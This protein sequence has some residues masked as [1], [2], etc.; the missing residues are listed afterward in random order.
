MKAFL[1]HHHAPIEQKPLALEEVPIPLPSEEDVLVE[2]FVCGICRT[3][4]HVIEGELSQKPLPLIPGHQIVGRIKTIGSKVSALSVGQRVGIAWLQATCGSCKF[5]LRGQENLCNTTSFTGWTRPG[6][7]AE[8]VVA[9]T[10]FIYPLPEGISDQQAAP[11]LCAG[12][13]GY[14]SLRLTGLSDWYGRKIGLY[15]FGSAAHISIQLLKSWGADVYV[16]SREQKHLDLATELGACW[17]GKTT[18]SLMQKLDA[19]IIY[20]PAGE[21]VV[22]A[23]QVSDKGGA[24]VC[25]GIHMSPIPSFEY[26]LIYGERIIRSVTNNTRQDGFEFLREAVRCGVSTHVNSF[27]FEETNDALIALKH[28]GFQGSGVI[29][30]KN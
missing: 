21:L 15:G 17:V 28:D 14:R 10:S 9:P 2:V 18:G 19:S 29:Q 23:L 13:I 6:G 5:C 4:L 24:I 16:V 30:I 7:F 22:Q 12:I 11:L 8:Y 26:H 27:P 20:A 25:A 3:D 1:L